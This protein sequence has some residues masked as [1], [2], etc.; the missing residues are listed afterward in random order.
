VRYQ[1]ALRPD[2]GFSREKCTTASEVNQFKRRCRQR[3]GAP[4]PYF[5]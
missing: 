4:M 5:V 2:D 3:P 1:A